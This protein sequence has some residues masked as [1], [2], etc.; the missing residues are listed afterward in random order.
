MCV[1][2]CLVVKMAEGVVVSRARPSGEGL[3]CESESEAVGETG[4]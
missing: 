3:A 1:C 4:G 2:V